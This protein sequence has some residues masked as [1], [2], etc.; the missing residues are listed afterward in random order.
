MKQNA[1]LNFEPDYGLLNDC[2]S[3]L[4]DFIRKCLIIAPEARPSAEQ[5]LREPFLL[6]VDNDD[7]QQKF[8]DEIH[9]QNQP[10]EQ[11]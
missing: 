7:L 4:Q 6:D 10:E 2:P 9:R 1:E 8:L 3:L 5:L 11:K